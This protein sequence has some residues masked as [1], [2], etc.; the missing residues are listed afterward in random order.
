MNSHLDTGGQRPRIYIHEV[1]PR[2]GLQS[3]K[4]DRRLKLHWVPRDFAA[5]ELT[6][7]AQEV[8]DAKIR[9][10]LPH[11]DH[12]QIAGVPGRHE[13]DNGEV[14]D[15]HIFRLLDPLGYES[16][17]GCEYIP[18]GDTAGGLTWMKELA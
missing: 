8:K 7:C 11:M 9:D 18:R 17:V 5:S 6:R 2:D 10:D 4:A 16:W 12:V 1:G 15:R 3:V 14:N 13:P